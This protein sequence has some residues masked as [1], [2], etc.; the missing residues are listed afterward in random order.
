MKEIFPIILSRVRPYEINAICRSM[1][2]N[3]YT[4]LISDGK[5][6]TDFYRAIIKIINKFGLTISFIYV[7]LMSKYFV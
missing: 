1:E 6:Y 3:N 2:I 4:R 5:I 7:S